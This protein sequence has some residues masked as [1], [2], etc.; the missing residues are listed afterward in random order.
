[1]S[2][3]FTLA[4]ALASALPLACTNEHTAVANHPEPASTPASGVSDGDHT[5]AKPNNDVDNNAE[6]PTPP[7]TPPEDQRIPEGIAPGK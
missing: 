2:F 4:L 1:M 5:G 3:R 7:G 6:H